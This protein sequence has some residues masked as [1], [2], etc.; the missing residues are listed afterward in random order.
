LAQGKYSPVGKICPH[1]LQKSKGLLLL[2]CY[3][4]N[5]F[6]E[7]TIT[8]VDTSRKSIIETTKEVEKWMRKNQR[9]VCL[10]GAMKEIDLI[11]SK[12]NG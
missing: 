3:I 8:L 4:F 1:T 7:P 10:L 12:N 5:K 2:Q 9:Q 6:S 11:V